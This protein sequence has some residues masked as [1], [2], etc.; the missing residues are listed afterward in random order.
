MEKKAPKKHYRN[1]PPPP[2]H[3]RWKKGQ[4]GNPKGRPPIP[5]DVRAARKLTQ[6]EFERICANLFNTS[7]KRL[8]EICRDPQTPVLT[9]L[10]A[11]I[12]EKG[13]AESSR[14]E[15]NYFIERF[16]GKVAENHNITSNVNGQLAD[17]IA[18][19]NGGKPK[20]SEDDEDFE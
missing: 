15:L 16:L 18:T 4:S 5:E 12:L 3:L 13:I 11:R 17:F 9:A 1:A 2:E 14:V 19:R 7:T 10:I 20:A 8:G 6:V